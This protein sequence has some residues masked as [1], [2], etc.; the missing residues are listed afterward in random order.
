MY[1]KKKQER[2]DAEDPHCAHKVEENLVNP[3]INLAH[4]DSLKSAEDNETAIIA[5][6]VMVNTSINIYNATLDEIFFR[7]LTLSMD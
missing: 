5:V 2:R 7:S 3:A 1:V 4:E 6:N